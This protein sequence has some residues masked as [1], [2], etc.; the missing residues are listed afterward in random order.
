M[1][2]I[3]NNTYKKD[4]NKRREKINLRN[5]THSTDKTKESIQI[6]D[7]SIRKK[8]KI[9]NNIDINDLKRLNNNNLIIKNLKM[10]LLFSKIIFQKNKNN[11]KKNIDTSISVDKQHRRKYHKKAVSITPIK[12]KLNPF[13]LKIGSLEGKKF[14]YYPFKFDS[15]KITNENFN[16]FENNHFVKAGFNKNSEYN[17]YLGNISYGYKVH[18]DDFHIIAPFSAIENTREIIPKTYSSA[19]KTVVDSNYKWVNNQGKAIIYNLS[20]FYYD[21]VKNNYTKEIIRYI[22][23]Y[24]VYGENLWMLQINGRPLIDFSITDT[25][26]P[27]HL[28]NFK[29]IN[30]QYYLGKPF[31]LRPVTK[32]EKLENVVDKIKNFRSKNNFSFKVNTMNTI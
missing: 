6:D 9:N 13:I 8:K 26:P 5:K 28:I 17:L 19:I 18:Y 29:N 15:D 31:F 11:L 10:N 21:L 27:E 3:T 1:L 16:P 24:E 20:L 23:K 12:K 22:S 4:M 32:E 14:I 25:N 2:T 30:E 7:L